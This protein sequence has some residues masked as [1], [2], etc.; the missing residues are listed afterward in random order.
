MRQYDVTEKERHCS[1]STLIKFAATREVLI[2]G[3]RENNF[4]V[5]ISTCR[6]QNSAHFV[7]EGYKICNGIIDLQK[8]VR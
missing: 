3:Y 1:A 4:K 6:Y 2:Y 8:R 5:Y 7:S